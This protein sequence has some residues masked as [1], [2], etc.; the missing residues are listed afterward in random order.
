M[1]LLAVYTGY[2]RASQAMETVQRLFDSADPND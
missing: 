2:A 1:T